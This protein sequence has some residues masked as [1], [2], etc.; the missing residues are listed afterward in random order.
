MADKRWE[1]YEEVAA[2]LL[3]QFAE[4]FG[5]GRFEEKQIVR[6]ESGTDWELDAIG[7]ADGNSK[8]VV[9]ECK[10]HL[11]AGISQAIA[12]S[13][14]WAIQDVGAEGGIIVSPL[15][16]QKGAKKVAAKANIIEVVLDP[17]SSTTEYVM[18][19][20]ERIHLGVASS[21]S[22]T[23]TLS[24]KKFDKEGNLVEDRDIK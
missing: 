4:H 16:L 22:F 21:V 19:F 15:G 9:V 13:L 8:V 11:K 7:Y 1:T 24:I 14:A 3:N 17:E 6:G 23:E 20:L 5:L 12:G 10:R 2:Y 18:K